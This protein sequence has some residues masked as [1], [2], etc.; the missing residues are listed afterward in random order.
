MN[1]HLKLDVELFETS[2]EFFLTTYISIRVQG[3]CLKA[4]ELPKE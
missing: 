4:S 3:T 1:I 2:E